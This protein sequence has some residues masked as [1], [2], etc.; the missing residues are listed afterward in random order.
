LNT[1]NNGPQIENGYTRIANEFLEALAR[2]RLAGEQM[3]C[4]LFILRKTWGFQKKT[5]AIPLSQ[6]VVGTG[7][8]KPNV[9]RAL[10]E[11]ENKRLIVIKND[12]KK[13]KTY[14][15]NKH[16]SRWKRLSK[17]I[18]LSKVITTV[19]KND[20]PSLSK[21]IT[22]KET[23]SKET[24]SKE[25]YSSDSIEVR[26]ASRLYDRIAL[27]NP[28]FKKPNFQTWA[29]HVDRMIRIDNR[30]PDEIEAVIDWCQQD[31][32]WDSNI[33]STQ[34]L[35]KQFDRLWI[36]MQK[37]KGLNATS[38]TMAHNQ[39]AIGQFISEMRGEHDETGP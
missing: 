28:K 19:I 39:Q 10:S 22:S 12:N 25:K 4:F 1:P 20:N 3:Q 2:Y 18:T 14:R 29:V 6:F 38:P 21:M 5:D 31:S 33:L 17:K 36:E 11:L 7:L 15:I 8:K 35:R 24:A 23:T 34:K 32:F 37:K 13:A 30:T 9:C 16:Y 26:L 27:N